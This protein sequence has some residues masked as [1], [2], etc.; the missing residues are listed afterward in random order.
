MRFVCACAYVHAY[1]HAFVNIPCYFHFRIGDDSHRGLLG[2]LAS[3]GGPCIVCE[4]RRRRRRVCNVHP[5]I[6][7]LAT[8]LSAVSVCRTLCV[9][10]WWS[11]SGRMLMLPP[12]VGMEVGGCL[13][14]HSHELRHTWRQAPLRL[15]GWRGEK[16]ESE[17]VFV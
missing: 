17:S 16:P 13:C 7:T 11:V 1:T 6:R 8:T 2:L 10:F 4:H 14:K 3:Y 9:W 12:V 15:V 5:L